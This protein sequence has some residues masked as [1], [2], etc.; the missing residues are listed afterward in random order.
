[1]K[2]LFNVMAMTGFALSAAMLAVLAV[3]YTQF[4][5]IKGRVTKSITAEVTKAVTEQLTKQ[6]DGKF[7]GMVDALPKKTGPALPF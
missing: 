4:D 7:D 2:L 6:L 1:M 3:A 5:S